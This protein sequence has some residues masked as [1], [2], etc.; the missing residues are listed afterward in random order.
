MKAFTL[1]PS[2]KT[3]V[4]C[5]SECITRSHLTIGSWGRSWKGKKMNQVSIF[6]HGQ[7]NNKCQQAQQTDTK[8]CAPLEIMRQKAIQDF[9]I[10]RKA[11]VHVEWKRAAA[12]FSWPSF[13]SS[14]SYMV[15]NI[16][17][18]SMALTTAVKTYGEEKRQW[19]TSTSCW[20][21][22]VGKYA[23]DGSCTA[24]DHLF[25]WLQSLVMS[26][27]WRKCCQTYYGLTLAHWNTVSCTI[28]LDAC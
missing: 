18:M 5:F 14:R 17:R 20:Q 27:T 28:Y 7:K 13:W 21:L 22:H 2:F 15:V 12:W 8:N 6:R 3:K 4:P 9:H 1:F 23:A 11:W 16:L 25:Q 10:W 19:K 26:S 24:V